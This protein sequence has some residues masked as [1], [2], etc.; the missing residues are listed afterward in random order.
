MKNIHIL[1]TDKPSKFIYSTKY[2]KFMFCY[3]A[4]FF[5]DDTQAEHKGIYITSDEEIK[6][7]DW[8]YDCGDVNFICKAFKHTTQQYQRVKI[9]LTTDQELIKDGVQAIDDEFLEWFVKNPSC[10]EV[11]V[12][13]GSFNL[14][15]TEEMLEKE[16]YVP[17]G[18]FD[19]YKIIIPQEEPKKYPIGG[20]APGNYRCTCVTCKTKFMGDKRAVQCEPCAIKM[21]Q[22]EPK[23]KIIASEEDAKVFVDAIKNPPAPNEELKQAFK[24]FSK[25]ETLEEAAE[26]MAKE[27]C[28]IRV[29]TNTTEFQIQ[30]LIIQGAKWQ[31]EQS[32]EAINKLISIIEWYD[33]ESDVRPDAE[34]FMWF[35]QFKKK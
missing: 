11:E 16:K 12:V 3:E 28:S 34:T 31:A 5:L 24:N 14:S 29:N 7:G 32:Q 21:T 8:Y 9:I 18:T 20:Y 35:E 17:T 26:R 13:K 2:N 4:P 22:E 30:Q 33:N 23:Q 10:D 25:Q 15:P 6:E 27:H 19:T 1:P